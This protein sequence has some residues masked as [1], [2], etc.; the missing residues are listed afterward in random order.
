MSLTLRVPHQIPTPRPGD[1]PARVTSP[2]VHVGVDLTQR[3]VIDHGTVTS[4][5]CRSC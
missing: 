5:G 1:R 2:C 4:T 3:R